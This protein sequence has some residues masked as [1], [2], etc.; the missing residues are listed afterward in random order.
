[1]FVLQKKEKKIIVKVQ[2]IGK[3]GKIVEIGNKKGKLEINGSKWRRA[4]PLET[5]VMRSQ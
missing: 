5:V 3:K 2:V 4:P 1:M